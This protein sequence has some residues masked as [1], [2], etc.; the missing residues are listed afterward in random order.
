MNKTYKLIIS[1]EQTSEKIFT[2]ILYLFGFIKTN[3]GRTQ[4]LNRFQFFFF[5]FCVCQVIAFLEKT[6]IQAVLAVMV[7]NG[8]LKKKDVTTEAIKYSKDCLSEAACL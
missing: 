6:K 2:Q 5:L 7:V 3:L 8:K 4:T 1:T